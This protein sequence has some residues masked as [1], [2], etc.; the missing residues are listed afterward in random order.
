MKMPQCKMLFWWQ[1]FWPNTLAI[2][3]KDTAYS[4]INFRVVEFACDR[5]WRRTECPFITW[6]NEQITKR[7]RYLPTCARCWVKYTF[8]EAPRFL[9]IFPLRTVT[10]IF[11]HCLEICYIFYWK[12]KF[13]GGERFNLGVALK[14]DEHSSANKNEEIR[15]KLCVTI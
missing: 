7:N 11:C 2:H 4:L 6:R 3:F 12:N 13:V 8:L 9:R 14:F 5:N 10:L 15:W 1:K